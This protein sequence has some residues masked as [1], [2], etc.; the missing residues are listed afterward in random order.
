MCPPCPPVVV[1]KLHKP[2][3]HMES[4]MRSCQARMVSACRL[5]PSLL[6]SQVA[7]PL[8]TS[9]L[10][11]CHVSDDLFRALLSCRLFSHLVAWDVS[12]PCIC[13]RQT[14]Q[15][16]LTLG[17]LGVLKSAAKCYCML[18]HV[19]RTRSAQDMQ[20]SSWCV[21]RARSFIVFIWL[22]LHSP[23][24]KL[25]LF[26]FVFG[27]LFRGWQWRSRGDLGELATRERERERQRLMWLWQGLMWWDG[28]AS[29][30]FVFWDACKLM[31]PAETGMN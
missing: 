10:C 20:A 3:R 23:H 4:M 6:S 5:P 13:Q 2:G 11:R 16:N 9:R 25:Q 29:F 19:R 31:H 22:V 17:K 18:A 24:G 1:F 27:P 14:V 30:C 8:R 21:E 15:P 26:E 7:S 28:G 12:S